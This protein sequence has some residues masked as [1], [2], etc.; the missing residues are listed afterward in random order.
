MAKV[1]SFFNYSGTLS[2]VTLV[3]SKRYGRHARM[4]RGTFTKVEINEAFKSSAKALVKA[5]RPA[6]IV[7]DALDPHRKNFKDGSLWQRLVS[8][9]KLAMRVD[10]Q[11][12]FMLLKGF[13]IFKKYPLNRHIQIE[14]SC[15]VDDKGMLHVTI[16]STGPTVFDGNKEINQ[17]ELRLI[18]V[19]P[20]PELN[21]AETLVFDFPRLPLHRP[22]VP[23]KTIIKIPV[24]V[25]A[26]LL[27]VKLEGWS[28][29][30]R[31]ANLKTMGMAIVNSLTLS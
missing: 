21:T 29:G 24:H 1:K 3:E 6:K 30:Y 4:R 14:T 23:Y 2:E 13:E 18:V 22:L 12:D 5:N 17:Y 15:E 10:S 26:A 31:S 28:R 27:C 25:Q 9:F 11:P 16:Q 19:F 8:V 7:K 20:Q